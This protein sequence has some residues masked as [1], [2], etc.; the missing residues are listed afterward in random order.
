M[1]PTVTEQK[2][3]EISSDKPLTNAEVYET[4]DLK[5]ASSLVASGHGLILVRHITT[6]KGKHKK[7]EVLFG[8]RQCQHQHDVEISFLSGTLVLNALLLLDTRDRFI[9]YISNGHRDI[10]NPMSEEVVNKKNS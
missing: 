10:L 9:S 2:R 5:L 7:P 6:E 3:I 8:F 1:T 4:N